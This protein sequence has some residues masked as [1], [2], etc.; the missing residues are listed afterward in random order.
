MSL[1]H[2]LGTLNSIDQE[3]VIGVRLGDQLGRGSFGTVYRGRHIALDIDVAVKLIT[4]VDFAS[5]GLEHTLKEARLMARLDHPN[6]LR[7]LDAGRSGPLVYFVL[8]L[9]NGG[10]CKS[11]H[12]LPSDRAMS[13]TKQLLSGL[14]A[15]HDA[16]I[17]HRDI[18]PANCLLRAEDGRIKLA[19]LGIAMDL[20][21]RT[22][23]HLEAA[24]TIPFM[25]P[26]LFEASPRFSERSD[27]Y[28]LGM[29]LACMVLD[30]DPFPRGA[31]DVLHSWIV[32]GTRPDVPSRRPDLSPA[33]TELIN[34]MISP[35]PADRPA[36]AAEAL[37]ALSFETQR[38]PAVRTVPIPSDESTAHIGPWVL[39]EQV[40]SSSNWLGHVVTHV[41]TGA[42]ARVMRLQPQSRLWGVSKVIL[43]AAA[44][45]S[46]LDHPSLIE[47]IDWGMFEG[48]PY[49]VTGPRGRSLG[50][51]ISTGNP[52]QE[53]VAIGFTTSLADALRYLHGLGLVYQNLDPGS[54]VVA[55]DARSARLSWPVYCVPAGSPAHAPA[56]QWQR[57]IVR[58]Y[59]A[60]EALSN[61]TT[62][63]EPSVDLFGLGVVL[64]YLLTGGEAYA[65][66][67]QS[68][69]LPDIRELA[70]T[71]TAP[72]ARLVAE[73]T[74]PDP[75][76]R[77][78]AASAYEELA[79]IGR[80]LGTARD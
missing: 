28:A 57:I 12:S 16:R 65:K 13:V 47:V 50:D 55:A 45:A 10:S 14:Q 54:A 23:P 76:Q 29:T 36:S 21:T 70:P 53:H 67:R 71:V 44:L 15:L 66:A 77:P 2:S 27:L 40:Y 51:L 37:A 78:V 6:L 7:I 35:K 19:D 31:F 34:R 25:A 24:G 52:C 56:G 64:Y 18:K 32:H 20:G 8:E 17:L 68:T 5:G 63:I 73:L 79:R 58:A 22:R 9:M 43:N 80:R 46:R 33:L 61:S 26:E 59:S 11:L 74:H 42:P 3:V 49:V 48:R 75:P 60:P 4:G 62:T 41:G 38:A 69:V 1:D 72:T 30:T 39:G